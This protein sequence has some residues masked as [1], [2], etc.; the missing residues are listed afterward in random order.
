[1]CTCDRGS[2]DTTPMPSPLSFDVVWTAVRV[3]VNATV[4]RMDGT[5]AATHLLQ[6]KGYGPFGGRTMRDMV[7][8]ATAW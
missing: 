6:S 1:M 5:I 4:W 7:L 3:R 8:P 2:L